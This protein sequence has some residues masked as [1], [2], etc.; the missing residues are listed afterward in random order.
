M[1]KV[2]QILDAKAAFVK[3]SVAQGHPPSP[4]QL[5]SFLTALRNEVNKISPQMI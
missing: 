1:E 3:Q 2:V 4:A 5:S